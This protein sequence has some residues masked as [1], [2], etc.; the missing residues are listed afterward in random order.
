MSIDPLLPVDTYGFQ[1]R[2]EVRERTLKELAENIRGFLHPPGIKA[3]KDPRSVV[4][5]R[6]NGVI[7][8]VDED[9]IE[10]FLETMQPGD[11]ITFFAKGV[12]QVF[13]YEDSDASGVYRVGTLYKRDPA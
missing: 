10:G 7:V 12:K 1:S 4:Y 9:G 13:V 8:V 3:L 2:R 11:H 5:R 6:A